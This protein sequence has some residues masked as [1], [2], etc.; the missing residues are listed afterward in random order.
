MTR[1]EAKKELMERLHQAEYVESKY[2]DCCTDDA[3]RLAISAL[4]AQHCE[5]TISRQA[6][7]DAI[8]NLP[9]AQSERK[10]GW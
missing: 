6:A 4:S 10:R 1:E 5:D 2:V 7:I 8:K 3:I 9:S